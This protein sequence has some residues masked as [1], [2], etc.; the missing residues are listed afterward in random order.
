MMMWA[1]FSRAHII[2]ESSCDYTGQLCPCKLRLIQ[3]SK[4]ALLKTSLED[5]QGLLFVVYSRLV[6][7]IDTVLYNRCA[8]SLICVVLYSAP[9]L[10]WRRFVLRAVN[11]FRMGACAARRHSF[12]L[13]LCYSFI[14]VIRAPSLIS[15]FASNFLSWVLY[16]IF[17]QPK[18][19]SVATFADFYFFFES[20][21]VFFF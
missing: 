20:G 7:F 9:S 8:P 21:V 11:H 16:D 15:N 5:R 17:N 1:F 6:Y 2:I 13:V 12:R 19:K 14:A 18:Q 4:T 10:I 3:P